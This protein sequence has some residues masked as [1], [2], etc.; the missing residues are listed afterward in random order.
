MTGNAIGSLFRPRNSRYFLE[1][2]TKLSWV[3]FLTQIA[4]V[5][6]YWEI[7]LKRT[8]TIEILSLIGWWFLVQVHIDFF[9]IQ[10]KCGDGG[11]RESN[12]FHM[13]YGHF[14][15]TNGPIMKKV[16]REGTAKSVHFFKKGNRDPRTAEPVRVLKR[17]FKDPRTAESVQFLKGNARI[18]GRP[19]WSKV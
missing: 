10:Y 2:W 11:E 19:N 14:H 15:S 9:S 18:N 8:W 3:I 6:V 4:E 13:K 1:S 17:K 16:I 7:L 12:Y 5:L